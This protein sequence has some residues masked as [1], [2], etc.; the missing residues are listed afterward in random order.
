MPTHDPQ[1]PGLVAAAR[2]GVPDA[3]D[4]LF[5]R[6]Q[7]PL[8]AY[9]VELLKDSAASLD[10]VQETFI[11]ALKHLGGLR[12]DARFGAWLFGIA[13]QL[14]LAQWRRL[15]RDPGPNAEPESPGEDVAFEPGPDLTAIRQEEERAVL[16]AIDELPPAQRSVILLFFLEDFSLAEIAEATATTLGTVKSRLHYAKAALRRK[17]TCLAP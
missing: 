11:R 4:A 15:G 3:W 17:L 7:L 13:H 14:I 6:Y 10:V 9:S 1:L 5:R 8:Y 12:E 16:A 2:Q